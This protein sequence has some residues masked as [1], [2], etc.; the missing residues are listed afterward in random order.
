MSVNR[1]I[2]WEGRRD[3]NVALIGGRSWTAEVKLG[4]KKN[5]K[6]EGREGGT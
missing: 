6:D 3:R 4:G 1:S 2:R 5:I